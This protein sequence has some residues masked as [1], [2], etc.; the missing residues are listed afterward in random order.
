MGR[1]L[2]LG[3]TAAG[4]AC[5]LAWGLGHASADL[6][7]DEII[8]LSQYALVGFA[9]TV[10]TYPDPNNHI[11]LNLLD[12][13]VTRVLGTRDLYQLAAHPGPLRWVQWIVAAGTGIYVLRTGRRFFAP[14]TGALALVYLVT[15]LPY[16]NFSMQLRGYNL[17]QFFAAGLVHHVWS[18]EERS[19]RRHLGATT[20]MAFGL[21]YTVPSNAY[22]LLAVALSIG[23][24]LVRPRDA[25][26]TAGAF[27]RRPGAGVLAAV[28]A[29]AALAFLAY[30]PVLH[31]LLDNRFVDVGPGERTFVLTRRL[32]Q[33]VL[34]LVSYRYALI[35]V[36]LAGFFLA[37]RRRGDLRGSGRAA[38]LLALL[39]LPFLFS[40]LRNDAPFERT[41]LVLAPVLALTLAASTLWFVETVT[42]SR[43]WRSALVAAAAVYALATLAFAV[44]HVQRRLE[45]NLEK[46]IR[47]QNLLA[48]FYQHHGFRPSLVA[49]RL[50]EAEG[51]VSAPILLVDELDRVSLSLYLQARGLAC[52]SLVRL[53][54][55]AE[56]GEATHIGLFEKSHGRGEDPEYFRAGLSLPETRENDRLTPVLTVAET[57]E[58]AP[59]YYVVT[60]FGEKNRAILETF[61]PGYRLEEIGPRDAHGFQCWL[62]TRR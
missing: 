19:S 57:Y 36:A 3:L 21:L 43:R 41:F 18:A 34:H 39:V 1:S 22:F 56:G 8:S 58:P 60:A 37:W 4:F 12:N 62:L 29:G 59:R 31:T 16:L 24:R 14:P 28:A 52:T 15:S 30:L 13:A 55:R 26:R 47:E 32:P 7:W 38:N 35:A 54:P 25:S 10:T 23:Y 51:R 48:S 42:A 33:V 40:F 17:S 50:T 44:D 46:G 53:S 11:L 2:S 9:R 61:H 6:W 45:D 5:L 27:L 49:A 20:L